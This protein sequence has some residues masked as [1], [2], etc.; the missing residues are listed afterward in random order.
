MDVYVSNMF[1]AAGN[2]ITFQEQFKPG[3]SQE[4]RKRLQR[5]ARGSTLL[6]NLDSRSFGDVSEV[7]GVARARW[8]WG[9]SFIDLNNNG[10]EDLVVANGNVTGDD[11]GDL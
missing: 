6:K 11:P 1:S 2:R 7:A 5:F 9:T 4:V 10:W 3:A 8:A